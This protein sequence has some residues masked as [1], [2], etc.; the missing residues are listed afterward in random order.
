MNIVIQL[1]K[2][3]ARM[4]GA[5]AILYS[6]ISIPFQ[7]AFAADLI[8]K[9][10]NLD[11]KTGVMKAALFD[12]PAEFP[13]G[14]KTA[15]QKVPVQGETAQ[16]VFKGLTDG[17]RYAVAVYHDENENNKF[18]KALFGIPLEGF[19]FSRDASVLSGAPNFSDA[20]FVMKGERMEITV[21]LKHSVFD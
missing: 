21:K 5:I 3:I 1:S 8:V 7:P 20:D 6:V 12:K 4:I 13:R 19:G 10:I 17:K 15:G 14:K 11:V 16:F 2:N 18:D 9:V